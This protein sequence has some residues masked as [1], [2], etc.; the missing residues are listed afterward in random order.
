VRRPTT[1][2][3]L[4][5]SFALVLGTSGTAEAGP[6][7]RAPKGLH[8][9]KAQAPNTLIVWKKSNGAQRYRVLV[10][11]KSDMRGGKSYFTKGKAPKKYVTKLK[12]GT[13]Y[14][15]KVRSVSKSRHARSSYSKTYSFVTRAKTKAP[16]PVLSY[17]PSTP[18]LNVSE[19]TSSSVTLNWTKAPGATSYQVHY[20]DGAGPVTV[21]R[22]GDVNFLRI[23]SLRS[24]AS[25]SFVIYA[26]NKNGELSS[27]SAPVYAT[28][29]AFDLDAPTSLS[30][31]TYS[32]TTLDIAWVKSARAHGYRVYYQPVNGGPFQSADAGDAASLRLTG[33]SAATTYRVYVVALMSDGQR[34]PNSAAINATTRVYDSLS[35][36]SNFR[37]TSRQATSIAL[38]WD[39]VQNATNYQIWYRSETGEWAVRGAGSGTSYRFNNLTPNKRFYFIISAYD[40]AGMASP[41]SAP[42]DIKTPGS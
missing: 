17:P 9:A 1:A 14:Y 40:N 32:M 20:R 7:Y 25:H 27:P 10:S 21:V 26:A 13:R 15:V 6:K 2:I 11:A 37:H 19:R 28:T 33:L 35:T 16:T 24:S 42:I 4:V 23:G 8:A 12:A 34:S 18:S 30:A 29:Y 5:A 41:Q 3:M 22:T 39:A 31:A 38:A 36:P